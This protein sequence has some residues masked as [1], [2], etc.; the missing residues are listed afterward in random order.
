MYKVRYWKGRGRGRE[1]R[2]EKEGEARANIGKKREK[3]KDPLRVKSKEQ[4]TQI[5]QQN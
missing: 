5:T 2:K 4:I 3:R 1:R